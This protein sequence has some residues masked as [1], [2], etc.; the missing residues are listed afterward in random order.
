[1]I[2]KQYKKEVD[3]FLFCYYLQSSSKKIFDKKSTFNLQKVLEMYFLR[4]YNISVRYNGK[5]VS[6]C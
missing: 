1:M 2:F 3:A 6:L 4:L 5:E